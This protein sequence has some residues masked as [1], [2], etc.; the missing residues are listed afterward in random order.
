M[1]TL[2]CKISIEHIK[3]IQ[4]KL[5]NRRKEECHGLSLSKKVEYS[6]I[7]KWSIWSS[8]N[9]S[10]DS[11]IILSYSIYAKRS[12]LSQFFQ[13]REMVTTKHHE[14]FWKI[15]LK[16]IFTVEKCRRTTQIRYHALLQISKKTTRRKNQSSWLGQR[17]S[18][19]KE[20]ASK[21][22]E[23]HWQLNSNSRLDLWKC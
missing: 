9:L 8:L 20:T 19:W 3:S 14:S 18:Y 12:Y 11:I 10:F 2:S 22:V 1:S 6:L 21:I 7:K 4:N 23:K 17:F 15:T 5:S 16:Q 13:S